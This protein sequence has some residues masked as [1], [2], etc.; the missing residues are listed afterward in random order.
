MFIIPLLFSIDF[1]LTL[2][3]L[4]LPVFKLYINGI[5]LYV[6][7]QDL[8]FQK[9]LNIVFLRFIHTIAQSCCSST[10]MLDL[11]VSCSSS[12]R[13]HMFYSYFGG[14][15]NKVIMNIL[16]H[17]SWYTCTRISLRYYL[18]PIQRVCIFLALID[19]SIILF[20]FTLP[21]AVF[22]RFYCFS[23]SPTLS[24]VILL[25]FVSPVVAREYP[26]VD[27]F[28]SSCLFFCFQ[29]SDC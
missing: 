20:L 23:S 15:E 28:F 19:N 26:I 10:F 18:G 29:I 25:I 1:F 2:N 8:L 3:I 6:P 11:M 22:E 9:S 5:I 17:V 21:R 24:H 12:F 16:H 13:G 4:I 14:I 27:S 7:L